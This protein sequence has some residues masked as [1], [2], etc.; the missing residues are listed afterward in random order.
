MGG[1]GGGQGAPSRP[2]VLCPTRPAEPGLH[3]SLR[4]SSVQPD[5]IIHRSPSLYVRA[6][7]FIFFLP[8]KRVPRL[9]GNS[10]YLRGDPGVGESL[11]L[12]ISRGAR[13]F[14]RRGVSGRGMDHRRLVKSPRGFAGAWGRRAGDREPR[15]RHRPWGPRS[16]RG[17]GSSERKPVDASGGSGQLYGAAAGASCIRTARSQRSGFAAHRAVRLPPHAS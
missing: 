14:L 4:L 12:Q 9:E 5:F 2:D 16:A 17:S 13:G 11:H 3:L 15:G 6:F 1:R 8:G 7:Y 10:W